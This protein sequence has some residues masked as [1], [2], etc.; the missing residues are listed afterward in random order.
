MRAR[1]SYDAVNRRERAL[2]EVDVGQQD[3]SYKILALFNSEIEYVYDF[4]ARNCT[5]R[6]LTRPWRD[7][8]IRSDTRSL[9]EVYVGTSALPSAGV[10]YKKNMLYEMFSSENHQNKIQK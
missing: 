6:P 2:K 7:F 5:R 3:N 10:L 8:G 4:K 9:G 1:L